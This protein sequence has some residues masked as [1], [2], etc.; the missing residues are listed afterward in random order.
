MESGQYI[1][2]GKVWDRS[3]SIVRN[4]IKY[5]GMVIKAMDIELNTSDTAVGE[6]SKKISDLWKE[7][8][9]DQDEVETSG[10]ALASAKA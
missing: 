4:I 10:S 2:V 8:Y 9:T 1:G 5:K 7:L 3:K 6:I